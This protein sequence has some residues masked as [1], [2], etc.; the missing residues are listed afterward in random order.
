[1]VPVSILGILLAL[2]SAACFAI[3][4][5]CARIGTDEGDVSTLLVI[6]LCTNLVIVIPLV[7]IRV[8][9]PSVTPVSVG[10]FLAAGL[11]GSL[12]ARLSLYR[13]VELI[14]A[15]RTA[16]VVAA[17]VFV[18]M[19]LAVAFL[20]ER[21]TLPH[22]GGTVLIVGGIAVISWETARGSAPEQSL[23]ELGLSLALPLLAATF[24]G[25]EPIF[26]VIGLEAGTSILSGFAIKT[27][28]AIAGFLSYMAWYGRLT[29]DRF[30]SGSNA[31]WYVGAGTASTVAIITYF[32]ALDLT[33]VV[34]VAPLFQTSPLIT[35]LI[36]ATF[37][38]RRLEQIT[39]RL[40]TAS[41]VV[42]IGA[43]LVSVA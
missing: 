25:I 12:L 30:R 10:S 17:N 35:F 24:I 2:T 32:A 20:D 34:L 41:I 9:L 1:M 29:R 21:L 42:V 14:G 7:A 27:L 39:W 3:D 33:S 22:L 13:S 40:V 15:S 36:S 5:I 38:P 28:A 26:V 19:V 11:F 4:T 43:A 18:S 16:P 8:G 31:K 6:S 37:L 23:R